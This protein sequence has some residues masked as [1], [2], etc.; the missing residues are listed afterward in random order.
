MARNKAVY[1]ELLK[2]MQ[3]VAEGAGGE[4]EEQHAAEEAG[5]A[6]AAEAQPGEQ[7][8]AQGQQETH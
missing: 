2:E 1:D 7:R 8:R 4:G 3:D 6:A 5:A